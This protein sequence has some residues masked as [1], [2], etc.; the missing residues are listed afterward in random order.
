MKLI[1]FILIWR[2]FLLWT[3]HKFLAHYVFGGKNGGPRYVWRCG[4]KLTSLVKRHEFWSDVIFQM[5]IY[6]INVQKEGKTFLTMFLI[7]NFHSW[8]I[9]KEFNTAILGAFLKK[10]C[11]QVNNALLG[12]RKN[13][14]H[15]FD[16]RLGYNG[17]YL[18]H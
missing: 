10:I 2:D 5:P 6:F 12:P 13:T 4:K 15:D 14:Y 9:S 11:N 17:H 7:G 16:H 8:K 18:C 3:F 1:N